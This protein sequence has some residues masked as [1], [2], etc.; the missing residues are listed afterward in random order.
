MESV[1]PNGAVKRIE[2][3]D[4]RWA[5]VRRL[6]VADISVAKI[7]AH[8]RGWDDADLDAIGL[9]PRV[10]VACSEGDVTQEF[11]GTLTEADFGKVWL[12]VKGVD[13]PNPSSPSS[14]GSTRRRGATS[15][16]RTNG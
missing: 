5:D 3:E 2:L 15:K 12:G 8:E 4:G 16:D 6:L 10:I 11:V 14:G 7:A 1:E 9:L 13:L